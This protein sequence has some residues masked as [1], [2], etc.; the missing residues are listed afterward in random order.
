MSRKD[1]LSKAPTAAE[2]AK[3]DYGEDSGAGFEGMDSSE[4]KIPF[5]NLLQALSPEVSDPSKKIPGAA[6]G[7][8]LNTV[9]RELIPGET[10]FFF[11]PCAREHYVVEW[12]PRKAGGGFVG[13]HAPTDDIVLT[14]RRAASERARAKG[15]NLESMHWVT[16]S[17]NDL[18]DTFYLYGLL[19]PSPESNEPTGFAL[20]PFAITKVKKYQTIMTRM[21]TKLPAR[22]PLYSNRLHVVAVPDRNKKGQNYYNLELKFA[23]DDNAGAST[24][25]PTLGD[26][27]HPLLAYGRAL[28][29]MVKAGQADVDF[30]GAGEAA[31]GGAPSEEEAF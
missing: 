11:V 16:A 9:T 26:R 31:V 1:E 8:F 28:Y 25:P 6:P 3:Y 2:L 13:R 14:A 15:D 27:R 18:I 30:S 7:M 24:I 29:T 12:V 22:S 17:G 4:L 21:D 20:L 10:G 23:I 5:M 19:L